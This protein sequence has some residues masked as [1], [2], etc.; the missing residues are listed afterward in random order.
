[1]EHS[2]MIG[3]I[4]EKMGENITEQNS[5]LRKRI[6]ASF[7]SW[8]QG[9]VAPAAGAEAPPPEE[10]PPAQQS[11]AAPNDQDAGAALAMQAGPVGLQGA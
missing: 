3:I 5:D 2:E 10:G 4:A 1:M 9:L 6:S 7:I 11:A 8:F